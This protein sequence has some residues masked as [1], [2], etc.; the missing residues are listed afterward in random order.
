M[1]VKILDF[2]SPEAQLQLADR[3]LLGKPLSAPILLFDGE[4][5]IAGDVERIMKALNNGNEVV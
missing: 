1:N 5:Y 2:D 3:E 4:E